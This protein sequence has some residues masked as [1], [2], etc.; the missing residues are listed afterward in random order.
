MKTRRLGRGLSAFLDFE[1][2][3]DDGA[4][5]VSDVITAPEATSVLETST[6]APPRIVTVAPPTKLSAP[7]A[8]AAPAPVAVPEPVPPADDEA[9]FIDDLVLGLAFPDVELE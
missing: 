2:A 3:G 1:P 4:A 6:A 8:V 9:A 7:P 5:R